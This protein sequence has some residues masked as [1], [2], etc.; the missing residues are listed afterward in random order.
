MRKG[1]KIE[2]HHKYNYI[3]YNFTYK[4]ECRNELK[5]IEKFTK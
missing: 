2:Y 1:V 3:Y 5:K 4:N